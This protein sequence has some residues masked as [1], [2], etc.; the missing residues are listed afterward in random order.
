MSIPSKVSEYLRRKGGQFKARVGAGGDS[1][2]SAIAEAKL[3]PARVAQA[4]VLTTGKS[5][6]MI[7]HPADQEPD[8]AAVAQMVKQPLSHATLQ[9]LSRLFP[10]CDPQAIPP[11]PEAF[12]L[13]GIVDPALTAAEQV[14]F[15]A[16]RL[17]VFVRATGADLARLTEGGRVKSVSRPREE[18][19]TPLGGDRVGAIRER[20]RHVHQLP[21]MPGMAMQILKLRNNPYS[22]VSELAAIVEQDPSLSA[23]IIRYASSPFFGYQGRVDSVAMAIARVLGMDFVMD[24]AFGLSLCKSFRNPTGGPL[25]LNNFW[26][27]ATFTGA[28]TQALCLRIPYMRRPS[29][30]IA[31]LSG[32][33]HNFGFLL[34]GHLFP[35]QFTRLNKA[36]AEHPERPITELEREILGISHADLGLWLMEAWGMPKEIVDAVHEHHNPAFRG[37][38]AVYANLVYIANALLSRHGIGE[39]ETLQIPQQL[40]DATGLDEIQAEAALG[41]VLES[42]ESLEFIARKMAA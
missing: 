17:G 25:G 20:V 28:L 15:S 30:G 6:L 2:H 11:L 5:V 40:L 22:H 7:V 3:L 37:D 41:T 34:L 9:D 42:R 26:Q 27:H 39:S 29:P 19:A 24:L 8:V 38:F 36:L 21:S 1:L 18:P 14:Y 35:D 32:L 31:Y 4:T 33:L 23:Q 12:G 13:K 10:D 16:G